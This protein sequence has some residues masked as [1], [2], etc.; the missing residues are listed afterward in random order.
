[1]IKTLHLSGSPPQSSGKFKEG[2][3]NKSSENYAQQT[4][5]WGKRVLC[6]FQKLFETDAVKVFLPVENNECFGV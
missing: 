4:M 2:G 1:V 5:E 3:E 6:Y